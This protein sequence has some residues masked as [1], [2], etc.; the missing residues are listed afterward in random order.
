VQPG[1]GGL[2]G[3]I[4]EAG[5]LLR[6][7]AQDEA[8]AEAPVELELECGGKIVARFLANRYREDL[9][10]AGLGSGCHAFELALPALRGAIT[11]RRVSDGAVL[12]A[13]QALRRAG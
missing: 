3:N 12:G 4:D 5:A 8:A 7:W 11:V 2:R 6:G 1:Q 13:P 10:A 9:R